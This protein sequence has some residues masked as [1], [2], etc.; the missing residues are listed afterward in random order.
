MNATNTDYHIFVAPNARH[1]RA[2]RRAL[3]K[4]HLPFQVVTVHTGDGQRKAFRL[5]ST[6]CVFLN[7]LH[8]MQP[9]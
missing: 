9:N 7:T 8:L 5:S 6:V 3:R 2:F 1:F 4:L